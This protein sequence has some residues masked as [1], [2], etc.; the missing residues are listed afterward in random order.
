MAAGNPVLLCRLDSAALL[1]GSVSVHAQLPSSSLGVHP[2]C[3]NLAKL[4]S[5]QEKVCFHPKGA[6]A[7]PL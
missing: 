7:I 4:C 3:I 2:E 5:F 6:L 1:Q